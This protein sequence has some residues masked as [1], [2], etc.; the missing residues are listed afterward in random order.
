MYVR[1]NIRMVAGDTET[2]DVELSELD[3]D[4]DDIV[5]T[6]RAYDS[7]TPAFSLAIGDG[8]ESLGENV[9]RVTLAPELT[10]GKRGLLYYSLAVFC[11]GDRYSVMLGEIRLTVTP[12]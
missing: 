11:G 9:Y 1:H 6:A 10:Q 5:L 2:F 4:V 7:E 12:T 3:A 8:I